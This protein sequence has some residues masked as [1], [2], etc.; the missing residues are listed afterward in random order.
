[1]K[2]ASGVISKEPDFPCTSIFPEISRPGRS[3]L[4]N[5]NEGEQ[6]LVAEKCVVVD[7]QCEV[8]QRAA[9]CLV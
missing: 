6:H 7:A 3:V 4:V 2:K 5:P 9:A 8:L 1:M